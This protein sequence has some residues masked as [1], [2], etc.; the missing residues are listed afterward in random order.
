MNYFVDF[1][2]GILSFGFGIINFLFV[3]IL[4]FAAGMIATFKRRNGFL[5]GVVRIFVSTEVIFDRYNIA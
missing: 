2:Q 3:F 5:W 4:A 1:L